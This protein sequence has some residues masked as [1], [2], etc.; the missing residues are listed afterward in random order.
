MQRLL[1][2]GFGDIA[3]RAAP[4]LE[5]RFT[6]DLQASAEVDARQWRSRG[7]IERMKEALARAWQ[8][9]L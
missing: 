3:R 8:Y 4:L 6:L 7:P 2:V 9:L 5:R 1:V